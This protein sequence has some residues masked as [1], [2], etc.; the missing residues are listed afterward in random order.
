MSNDLGD[1]QTTYWHD[2]D[3]QNPNG[4]LD[5]IPHWNIKWGDWDAVMLPLRRAW[6]TGENGQW[7]GGQGA[8]QLLSTVEGE[9]WKS[10]PAYGG[11]G[12]LGTQSAPELMGGGG[13]I[14]IGGSE[15]DILH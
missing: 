7:T 12:A 3:K 1:Y 11:G 6:Y 4:F 8:A 13:N 5:N 2:P 15:N 9:S 10:L 14:N